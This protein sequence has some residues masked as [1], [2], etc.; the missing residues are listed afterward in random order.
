MVAGTNYRFTFRNSDGTLTQIVTY[1]SLGGIVPD[2][3]RRPSDSSVVAAPVLISG[4]WRSVTDPNN[5]ADPL[6]AVYDAYPE[7]RPYLVSGVESQVVAGQNYKFGLQ[8]NDAGSIRYALFRVFVSLKG[9]NFVTLVE[10]INEAGYTVPQIQDNYNISLQLHKEL[11]GAAV[12]RIENIW[13]KEG[14]AFT[15]EKEGKKSQVFIYT[16][17]GK[18]NNLIF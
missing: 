2:D 3:A 16:R 17:N 15:L 5:Y 8:R 9:E 18:T 6:K 10:W 7:V 11:S 13:K 4:G 12:T 1:I 14:L